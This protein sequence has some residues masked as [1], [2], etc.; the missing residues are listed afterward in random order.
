M[1]ISQEMVHTMPSKC[2]KP[3]FEMHGERRVRTCATRGD[4][5]GVF[6]ASL[7]TLIER[8]GE[9]DGSRPGEAGVAFGDMGSV[10]RAGSTVQD[11]HGFA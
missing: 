3:H 2:A 8:R 4:S 9:V 7:L 11:V 6:S 5:S 10:L 1:I